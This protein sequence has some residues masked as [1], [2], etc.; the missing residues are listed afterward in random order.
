LVA[1]FAALGFA[2]VAPPVQA[3]TI[4][5]ALELNPTSI[6]ADGASHSTATATVTDMTGSPLPGQLVTFTTDGDVTFSPTTTTT[7][8]DGK[9]S[10]TISASTTADKEPITATAG[11][12][13]GTATLTEFGPV[14]TVTLALDPTS[15]RADGASHSTATATL[16]DANGK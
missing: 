3:A 1:L 10:S 11:T 5:V 2:A 9:A 8:L 4:N 6:P 16:K 14:A 15:I 7:G 13:S 12:G